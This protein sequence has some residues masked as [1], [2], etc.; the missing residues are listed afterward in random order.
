MGDYT[1]STSREERDL[2][3]DYSVR[4]IHSFYFDDIC[5][6]LKPSAF[7]HMYVNFVSSVD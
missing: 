7:H 3:L 1:I 2:F 6:L 5:K 4:F